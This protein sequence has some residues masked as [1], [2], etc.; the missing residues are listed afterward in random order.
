MVTRGAASRES[1]AALAAALDQIIDRS[2]PGELGTLSDDLF[3]F[4]H[5][6]EREAP[7][8]RALSDPAADP[9]RRQA[10]LDRVLGDR[11]SN[12]AA[13][14]L[15]LAVRSRWSDPRDLTEAA[16]S[17]ARR[18]GLGVAERGGVLDALARRTGLGSVARGGGALDEVEDE[19][20]RFGRIIDAEP[21]LRM[22]LEDRGAPVEGRLALLDRLVGDR[23]NPA[24]R[25]LLEQAVRS[26][27]GHGLSRTL[28]ELVELAAARRERYV[29]YVTVAAS[30]SEQQQDRL[31]DSLERVY[32][33]PV[34]LRVAVD[35][36][37]LG[38]LV[39]RVND[40]VIDGSVASRLAGLRHRLAD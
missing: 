36:D 30:L 31:A 1:L 32:G 35:P 2:S 5:L 17:L 21:R 12:R 38:G 33:H 15:R 40:E 19:L 29:A 14:L 9:D 20:F 24:T 3:G 11:V 26:P 8:R 13:E 23:V 27:R 37:L 34:S 18:A 7:L 6:L 4:A 25:R 39:V 22:L 28:T 10:L 16:E